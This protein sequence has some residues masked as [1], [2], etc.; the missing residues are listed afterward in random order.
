MLG[1]LTALIVVFLAYV[2]VVAA[3]YGPDEFI[4]AAL[5]N[6]RQFEILLAEEMKIKYRAALSKTPDDIIAAVRGSYGYA[7]PGT[8]HKGSFTIVSL[9]KL[10][11]SAG[12]KLSG[13]YT[14]EKGTHGSEASA[15]SLSVSVP[16]VRNA[17]GL[18]D[19]MISEIAGYEKEIA[20]LQ[21]A[22]AYEN[23]VAHLLKVYYSWHSDYASMQ[24]GA[25]SLAEAERFH[26]NMIERK[27]SGVAY[28]ADVQKSRM[29]LAEKKSAAAELEFKYLQS[30]NFI[31]LVLNDPE[32]VP[33]KPGVFAE[34]NIEGSVNEIFSRTRPGII[35]EIAVKKAGVSE[36]KAF[37]MLLPAVEI[38]AE[39]R[40]QGTGY[41]LT[42]NSN[43]VFA[44]FSAS[45]PVFASSQDM[46]RYEIEK[47]ENARSRVSAG[48]GRKTYVMKIENLKAAVETRR[49]QSLLAA[50]KE[51]AAE[52]VLREEKRNY[53][54]ARISLNDLIN[55]VN[56]AE[57]AKFARINA[58]AALSAAVID[59]RRETD[60]LVEKN[61]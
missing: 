49:E 46:A 23:Y 33:G 47:L 24:A 35:A 54:Q 18:A 1:K 14:A 31:K 22:E 3:Q 53:S 25:A 48:Y 15:A 17:F 55:A 2:P 50:E 36:A 8:G 44:G 19:R 11:P 52:A 45:L 29:Q 34:K 7:L 9:S 42:S 41:A 12:V 21:A 40:T 56:S 16:V 20:L 57:Q 5:K 10:F 32:P 30:L 37:N 27:R 61:E 28:E 26:K 59:Y 6:D 13:S 38:S 39:V 43:S 4:Q 51:E 60:T 58:E